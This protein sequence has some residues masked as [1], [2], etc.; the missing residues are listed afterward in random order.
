MVEN[1]SDSL[2]G[3]QLSKSYYR[4]MKTQETMGKANAAKPK[5]KKSAKTKEL[6]VKAAT[7]KKA[8]KPTKAKG[9][10]RSGSKT[11]K[12]LELMGTSL[13][14][15]HLNHKR[16]TRSAETQSGRFERLAGQGSRQPERS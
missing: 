12:V 7:P 3:R 1:Y 14:R 2:S 9:G 16:F 6:Q 15:R 11:E 10:S 4:L 13:R 8:T 5:N